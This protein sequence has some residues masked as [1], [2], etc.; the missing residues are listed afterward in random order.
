[1]LTFAELILQ[2]FV[3]IFN[4]MR[5]NIVKFR[6]KQAKSAIPAKDIH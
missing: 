2:E 4:K 3:L 6:K 1:M 5:D